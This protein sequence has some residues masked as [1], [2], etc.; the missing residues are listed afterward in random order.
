[1]RQAKFV[2]ENNSYK[3][4]RYSDTSIAVFLLGSAMLFFSCENKIERI[5]ELSTSERLATME[6]ENFE[7]LKSDSSIVK[8]RLSTPLM[9]EYSQNDGDE[10]SYTEFPKG[11]KIEQFGPNMKVSSKMTSDYA[12]FFQKE[13]KWVAK[14]NV[15]LINQKGDTL[16]TEELIWEG[17]TGKI[18]S[19]KFVKVIGTDQIINGI[20]FESDQSMTN[21]QIKKIRESSLYLEVNE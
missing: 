5:K 3:Q 19:D 7:M 21:W 4:R 2:Q 14:N 11:V 9:I 6:A 18:Y 15:V 8:F 17:K 1:M 13:E 12:Q 16:K 20:G 10:V